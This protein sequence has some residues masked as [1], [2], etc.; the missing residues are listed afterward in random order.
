[1]S[2]MRI[3]LALTL[4]TAACSSGHD[5]DEPVNCA[6][7]MRDEEFVAG[8]QKLGEDGKI[9]FTLVQATPAPPAR[10]DN[11]WTVQLTTAGAAAPVTG[12]TM[13]VTPHM[14]D[15]TH[16]PV[17]DQGQAM[18]EAGKYSA[19]VNMWMPGLWRTTIQATSGTDSDKAVF[20]FCVPS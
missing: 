4:F 12:A 5:D 6:E 7:E 8:M 14:P 9:T 2:T 11:T 1:M 18:P 20:V 17:S 15:H 16:A 19:P 13:I 3:A 10:G